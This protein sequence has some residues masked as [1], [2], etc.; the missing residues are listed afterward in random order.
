MRF[1]A[2]D[3]GDKRT[4]LAVADDRASPDLAAPLDVLEIPLAR[5]DGVELIEALAR[6]AHDQLGAQDAIVL[7]LPLNMDG[8]EGPRAKN[9]RAFAARLESR[10]KRT[11]FLFDERLTSV[12]AEWSLARSGFTHDQKKRRRDAIAAAALLRAFLLER[13]SQ[14]E[15]ARIEREVDGQA[16]M[17]RLSSP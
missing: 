8:S 7:G 14:Q 15:R 12:Q 6:A 16:T 3:L 17:D 13:Q 5:R 11:V 9:A 4:G 1:L 2:I 10:V